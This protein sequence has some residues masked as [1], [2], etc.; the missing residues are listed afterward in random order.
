M[1]AW[2][3]P[4]YYQSFIGMTHVAKYNPC[5]LSSFSFHERSAKRH[6]RIFIPN[7]R[8]LVFEPTAEVR[9]LPRQGWHLG[10]KYLL[11]SSVFA[12]YYP[13]GRPKRK[14]P[15]QKKPLSKLQ[16]GTHLR[17]NMILLLKQLKPSL[18]RQH[19]LRKLEDVQVWCLAKDLAQMRF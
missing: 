9:D 12:F 6:S 16:A 3:P 5:M 11:L 18:T 14:V 8:R 2:Y 1:Y 4:C 7:G 13:W 17:R 10:G 19:H 15:Q